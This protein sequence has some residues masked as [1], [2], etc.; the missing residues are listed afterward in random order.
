MRWLL[1]AALALAAACSYRA[2]FGDCEIQCTMPAE[3]PAGF[4]CGAEGL[5][6]PTGAAASCAAIA[7]A[8]AGD[9]MT[10]TRC[11]GQPAACP[12]ITGASACVAQAGCAYATPA[13]TL[14]DDCIYPTSTACDNAVG[15]RVT[16]IMP[17]CERIPGYC[18]GATEG[19]CGPKPECVFSG[20]CTG[21]VSPC[22][23]R[24]S[25]A[26][27]EQHAGCTWQ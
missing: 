15:C 21:A 7:D 11:T 9:V 13:C 24:T 22:N 12:S 26:A 2:S 19:A 1:A 6:R 17:Y 8:P 5:C 23:T 14:D 4:S 27:C 18:S 16:P 3:C 20:G 10:T 25:Q